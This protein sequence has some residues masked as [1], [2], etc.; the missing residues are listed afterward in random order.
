MESA[1]E[2]ERKEDVGGGGG[3]VVVWD[4]IGK[5]LIGVAGVA[6][7]KDPINKP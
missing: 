3:V 1:G 5:F 6:C 4:A 2:D 7:A